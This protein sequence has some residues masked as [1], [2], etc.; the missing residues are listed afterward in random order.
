MSKKSILLKAEETVYG[1]SDEHRAYGEFTLSMQRMAKIY[2]AL[3]E[4]DLTAK[5]MFYA[6]LAAKLSREMNK[7]KRD[8]LVDL[9]GYAAGLNDMLEE[10]HGKEKRK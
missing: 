9:C 10:T 7:H 2:N 8:N 4:Q 3:T 5:D 6:M 1:K